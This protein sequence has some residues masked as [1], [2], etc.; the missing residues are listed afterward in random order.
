MNAP[1]PAVAA[2]AA[3]STDL[4]VTVPETVLPGGLV[5]PAFQIAQYPCSKRAEGTLSIAAAAK[6]WVDVSYHSAVKACAAAGYRLTRE[7]QHLALAYQIAAQDENWTGGKVGAGKLY[8][9]FRNGEPWGA[10]AGNF[11]PKNAGERTWHVL[12][13]G[14]RIYHVAG[15]VFEW[16]FDDVQGDDRGL[17]AKPFAENSP[18]LAIPYP[19]EDKGQGWMPRAGANWS[20]HALI[21]GGFWCSEADAG[22]F[23][24]VGDWPDNR[25][26]YV[27]FR[28]TKPIGL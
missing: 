8:Q 18:S 15:N 22:V 7:S 26:V 19:A 10:Q 5:V 13:G 6:P 16:I 4:F 1:E 12:P 17:I 27:G 20:G 11:K 9:G 23:S 3:R 2:L 25:D 21:R 28:C 14:Q 24:L